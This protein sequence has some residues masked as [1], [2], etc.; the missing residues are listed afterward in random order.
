MSI[1][2]YEDSYGLKTIDAETVLH[3]TE[4]GAYVNAYNR[5]VESIRRGQPLSVVITNATVALWFA[6]M[7]GKYGSAV[8]SFTKVTPSAELAQRWGIEVP[9]WVNDKDIVEAGLLDYCPADEVYR[10]FE[11]TVLDAFFSPYLVLTRLPIRR[12]DGFLNDIDSDRWRNLRQNKV[13]R[14]V[15]KDRMQLWREQASSSEEVAVV[16]I[17]DKRLSRFRV[18]ICQFSIIQGYPRE[19]GVRVLGDSFRVLRE[20]PLS[21]DSLDISGV[22]L[23]QVQ[24]QIEVY[25]NQFV[26]RELSEDF[27]ADLLSR[28]SGRLDIEY[29]YIRR[30]LRNISGGPSTGL[31]T[32]VRKRFSSLNLKPQELE[33]FVRP[34]LPKAPD[35][36]W[37]IQEWINWATDEYLP[38]FRWVEQTGGCSEDLFAFARSYGDYMYSNYLETRSHYQK[39]V[40]RMLG[41]I[42]DMVAHRERVLFV[43]VDNLGYAFVEDLKRAFSEGGFRLECIDPYLTMV[44]SDTQSNKQCILTGQPEAFDGSKSYAQAVSES[45]PEYLG[46][47]VAYLSN[48]KA[49]ASLTQLDNRVY[50][51]NFLIID[52]DL[53]NDAEE[54]GVSHHELVRFRLKALVNAIS[55]FAREH[56]I[57]DALTVVVGSDHGSTKLQSEAISP[58]L[59]DFQPQETHGRYVVLSDSQVGKLSP[60]LYEQDAYLVERAKYGTRSNYLVARGHRRF[61]D[62]SAK[63]YDH[64]GLTPEETIVPLAVFGCAT[65]EI[66][67]P[68][69]LL[70]TEEFRYSVKSVVTLE[71]TNVNKVSLEEL[72]AQIL[73]RGVTSDV[74]EPHNLSAMSAVM[75]KVPCRISKPLEGSIDTLKVRL[76]YTV[77]ERQ[78]QEDYTVHVSVKSMMDLGASLDDL[79]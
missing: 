39:V 1:H 3:V 36:G 38:Y 58:Y 35:K 22:D 70:K 11:E 67:R 55:R 4:V 28:V 10:S 79:L 30:L 75:V 59:L 12:M 63:T 25:L 47:S 69:L 51:L 71:V 57:R 29:T 76:E 77:A 45:W 44:P 17:L 14:R 19:V 2:V 43:I 34:R 56:E 54:H 61:V 37:Q 62:N 48:L 50:F 31:V 41:N 21:L 15:F 33:F 13:F 73:T 40:Y 6:E 7:S 16:D 27:V 24:T 53:H 26:E 9:Q 5:I 60:E 42:K 46:V 74:S 8:V 52:R 68:E 18:L 66:A 72:T 78:Y 23:S 65:E 49:L 20:L 64:G 32:L